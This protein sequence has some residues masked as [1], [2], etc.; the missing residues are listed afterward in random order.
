MA[1]IH[2][3][4]ASH[5]LLFSLILAASASGDYYPVTVAAPAPNHKNRTMKETPNSNKSSYTDSPK[6]TEPNTQQNAEK[7]KPEPIKPEMT[8]YYSP[9]PADYELTLP[10]A[11]ED[12]KTHFL[13]PSANLALTTSPFKS[14][15]TSNSSVKTIIINL[16]L[17]NSSCISLF[18]TNSGAVVRITCWG[19]DEQGYDINTLSC[20]SGPTDAKGYFFKTLRSSTNDNIRNVWGNCKAFLEQSPLENYSVPSDVN[21]GISGSLL[22]AY[23]V[24]HD[25]SLKL[26]SVGP[27]FYTSEPKPSVTSADSDSDG[28]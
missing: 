14:N 6:P 24:L 8:G 15:S 18:E 4:L 27:F 26:Y 17:N 10:K 25:K 5:V 21:K 19:V 1:A 3:I 12:L 11:E 16:L 20:Q 2:F 22:S 13:V 9:K 7:P 23:H 28:Y